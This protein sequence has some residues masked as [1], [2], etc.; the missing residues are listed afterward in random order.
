MLAFRD[1]S[2]G[3]AKGRH[4][5]TAFSLTVGAGECVGIVG[6]SGSGKSTI[7]RVA[8]GLLPWTSGDVLFEGRSLSTFDAAAWK[9]YRRAVQLV[10]Q[11]SLG[12]L[13]PRR[14]VKQTLQEVVRGPEKGVRGQGSGVSDLLD[15]VELPLSVQD[16][17]PHELSGGQ[18]QRV[19]LA[20]ALAVRP[21]LL[22]ADEPVSALDVAVQASIIHLLDRLRRNLG[23]ALLFIGHDL[24]V[25]RI[26]CSRIAVMHHGALVESG[27]TA[28]VLSNPSAAY[29]RSLLAAVM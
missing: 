15:L 20:R 1:I 16:S 17:T 2:A 4:A 9:D 27:D 13:N 18:R 22:I 10:F 8:T 11:D 6:E 14:T 21:R 19:A 3:Y 12:A 23:M 26:L 29:T 28:Q 24:A 5:V 25:V 7:A